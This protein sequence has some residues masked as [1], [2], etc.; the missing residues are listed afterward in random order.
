LRR[1]F[2]AVVQPLLNAPGREGGHCRGAFETQSPSWNDANRHFDN[3]AGGIE[4]G[5]FEIVVKPRAVLAAN[6]TDNK[7][8]AF[9]DYHTMIVNSTGGA[10]AW[11]QKNGSGE[12]PKNDL[13]GARLNTRAVGN[14][15]AGPYGTE[16]DPGVF[17]YTTSWAYNAKH[18]QISNTFEL[19]QCD[20]TTDARA[21]AQG[22]AVM[23]ALYD[24]L[25]AGELGWYCETTLRARSANSSAAVPAGTITSAGATRLRARGGC[26]ATS[27]RSVTASSRAGRVRSSSTTAA[28]G[29]IL[30]SA[31][32]TAGH[33]RTET[34]IAK[35]N[36]V[37][38]ATRAAVIRLAAPGFP[39]PV[40]ETEPRGYSI[41][42][43]G[44]RGFATQ[45][46][47]GP[48]GRLD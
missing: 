1:K 21:T 16:Y 38:V 14:G 3:T 13:Y 12:P 29:T 28:E 31:R 43:R 15:G 23:L 47:A 36:V 9:F 37:T 48:I 7:V 4:P 24:S 18:A 11:G 26:T 22:N 19:N 17:K 35:T 6:M 44:S 42:G 20:I 2:D 33:I 34:G 40:F 25:M 32:S 45:G 10:I 39:E 27:L 46:G 5:S 30:S 8:A 41:A